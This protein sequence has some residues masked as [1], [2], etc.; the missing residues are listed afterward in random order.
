MLESRLD[1]SNRKCMI[2][3]TNNKTVVI[4]NVDIEKTVTDVFRI[5][6]P[7]QVEMAG[8]MGSPSC[9]FSRE[10]VAHVSSV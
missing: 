8:T 3:A 6:L 10:D 9:S 5:V 7:G 4:L 2:N 1:R